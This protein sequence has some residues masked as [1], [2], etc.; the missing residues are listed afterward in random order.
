[1]FKTPEYSA[2]VGH[3]IGALGT[4]R[5]TLPLAGL[6]SL[7]AGTPYA[8]VPLVVPLGLLFAVKAD[9]FCFLSRAKTS[10]REN[11]LTET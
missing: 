1:M 4:A 7:L 10:N 6:R 3:F 2:S 9:D 5:P 8:L 11:G